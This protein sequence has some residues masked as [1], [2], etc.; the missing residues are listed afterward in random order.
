MSSSVFVWTEAEVLFPNHKMKNRKKT[1]EI[2]E[3]SRS[4][5][6][7]IR[8]EFGV[9]YSKLDQPGRVSGDIENNKTM[10]MRSRQSISLSVSYAL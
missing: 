6:P 10:Y 7:Q 1:N 2:G 9:Y 5:H 3:F 4:N 8:N